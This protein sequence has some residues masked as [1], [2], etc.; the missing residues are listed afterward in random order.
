MAQEAAPKTRLYPLRYHPEQE[1]LKSSPARFKVVPAGR[2]SGKTELA[3]RN[4]IVSALTATDYFDPRFFAGA[5]TRD[6]AKAIYWTDLKAMVPRAL[7]RDKPRESDLVINLRNG[8]EI[9]VIGMDRP[10][11]IE[12]RPWNG[13][14]LDEFANMKPGA[15][16]ENVRPA[17]SDRNGWC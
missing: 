7:L 17:L 15:W 1:R 2:R 5:P 11:R 14:I 6:Q 9:C 4:L 3:K 10:E 8:A 13:G 12:G 16:G